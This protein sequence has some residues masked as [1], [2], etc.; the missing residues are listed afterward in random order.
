M[1]AKKLMKWKYIMGI[2][3]C[4]LG[5]NYVAYGGCESIAQGSLYIWVNIFSIFV[6]TKNMST[7]GGLE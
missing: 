3:F 1:F 7:K 4:S 5:K 6:Y 2:Q